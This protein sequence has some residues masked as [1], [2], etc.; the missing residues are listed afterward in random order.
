MVTRARIR[1]ALTALALTSAAWSAA[2]QEADEPAAQEAEV[3]AAEGAPKPQVDERVPRLHHAPLSVATAHEQVVIRADIDHPELVKRA[4]LVYRGADS[5]NLS[6]VEFARASEG[7][8]A[9]IIPADDV[10]WPSLGYCIEI[11]P[12]Q[13]HR[14][15]V[16]A[17]RSALHTVQ[18]PEDLMDVRERALLTRLQGRRSVFST[19]GEYVSFGKSNATQASGVGTQ[20]I[21]DYYWRVEG[22]YTFRPLRVVTEFSVRAGVVRGKAPVPLRDPVPGVPESDR[23]D[24]GLNYGAPS[25]RFRLDDQIHIEGEALISVTEVGFSW[26]GGSSLL[27]GDPYGSKLVLGF[28]SVQVF[29]TRFFSRM[30]VVASDR[31]TVA[32]IVE[33]TNMPSADS[34]GVRLLGEMAFD[35]GQG[36][37]VAARGGYQARRATS[38]GPALGATLS[39]AF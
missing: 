24:V 17:S 29:G 14:I 35:A 26:G 8:Y 18:V 37:S 25:V 27:L 4:L 38:G 13:G 1:I 3:P 7:P 31:I 28:E 5:Q 12:V 19:T 15:P 34:Y 16:F 9:A 36:F 2:A 6:E 22:G 39:Y 32:P 23:Y 11:E 10:R 30:D 33:V 20:S 21:D